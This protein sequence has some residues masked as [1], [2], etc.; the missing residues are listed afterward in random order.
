VITTAAIAD[1]LG[2][3]ASFFSSVG[4]GPV[5]CEVGI[6][7]LDVLRDERLPENAASVGDQL[8]AGLEELAARHEI[9]GA[10]HGA[11]L[12]L[13]VE[14]VRDRETKEPAVEEAMALCERM[15]DLGVI[16]QPTGD[17]MNVLKVK[18]PLCITRD[19]AAL[20]VA[21]LDEVLTR[22]W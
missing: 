16:V 15:L 19:D 7:V 22:R 14:L 10:V 4:G 9:I 2:R 21:A 12:Y 1:A 3:D 11:G 13:G 18:P 5:S 20:A 6:A 8:R 17:F